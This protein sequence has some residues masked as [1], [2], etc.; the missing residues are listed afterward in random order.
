MSI[1]ASRKAFQSLG[2]I[3]EIILR[4]AFLV[5]KHVGLG[6]GIEKYTY[7][8]GK[9][10]V[11]RGHDVTIYS[12]RHYG[13]LPPKELE[14]MRVIGVPSIHFS[15]AEKLS[16]SAFA[17][18]RLLFSKKYDVVHLHS[19][20]SGAFSVIPRFLRG[21]P[22]VL[23]M[24]GIEW[25]R[26]RWSG[27]GQKF[28]RFLEKIAVKT[29]NSF[30]AVSQV[31]CDF[32]EKHYGIRTHYI[33]TGCEQ[34]EYVAPQEILKLGL[35]PQKYILFASRLVAEKGP[36]YLIPAY[37][38]LNTDCKLVIAGDAKDN[39]AFKRQLRDLAGNDPRIIF[40][41]FVSGRLLDELFHHAAVY[42]QPSELEGLSIALLE[43]LGYGI[44]VLASNI[45]ENI[46][47]AADTGYYFENKSVDDLTRKLQ[48]MLE[49]LDEANTLAQTAKQRIA[50]QFNWNRITDEFEK[51][52]RQSVTVKN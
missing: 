37:R 34:K 32:Y 31:Q 39:E 15:F 51:L 6:G 17:I 47:A 21:T 11:Q 22:T 2:Q 44:P 30:T 16:A 45:P 4:V 23:Q 27:G 35:E 48:W 13:N 52:Y 12:M 18:L 9:R 8:L 49:N 7:E 40:P 29:S 14:G 19:V 3:G 38:K 46:E 28:L 41:G 50:K 33:P 26:S 5:V 42:V 43:G 20:A 24:H 36:Q 10:L 25:Q 1:I